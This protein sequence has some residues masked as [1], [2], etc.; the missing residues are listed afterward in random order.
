MGCL[1][2][3]VALLQPDLNYP[4]V[5]KGCETVFVEEIAKDVTEVL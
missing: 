4:L 5:P 3:G 2:A 1:A